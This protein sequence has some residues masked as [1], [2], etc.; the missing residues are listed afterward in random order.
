[1]QKPL[2]ENADRVKRLAEGNPD[3]TVREIANA[4]G[5]STQRVYQLMDALRERGEL[6]MAGGPTSSH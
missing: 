5:L 1:M 6:D 4:L 2:G 3:L